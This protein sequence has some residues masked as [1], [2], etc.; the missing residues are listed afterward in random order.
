MDYGH[1]ILL[2]AYVENDVVEGLYIFISDLS[3]R[4]SRNISHF[5]SYG[6]IELLCGLLTD[7][8]P[9][10][11]WEETGDG[12]F[13]TECE[14]YINPDYPINEKSSY[15]HCPHCGYKIV[16]K[17]HNDNSSSL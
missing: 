10:C 17:G 1:G 16:V 12:D 4:A 13:K 9:V 5:T 14:H 2:C 8:E 11:K 15:Q 6:Q 3:V 7:Q